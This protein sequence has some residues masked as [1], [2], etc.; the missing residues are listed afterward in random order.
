MNFGDEV[1][2]TPI[3]IAAFTVCFI[4][5]M[6]TTVNP[7]M[8]MVTA[9]TLVIFYRIKQYCLKTIRNI[10]RIEDSREGAGR[11]DQSLAVS[12]PLKRATEEGPQMVQ[13]ETSGQPPRQAANGYERAV[14]KAITLC[15]CCRKMV[16]QAL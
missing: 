1:L 9:V 5:L 2:N 14:R 3:A 13:M 12:K 7:W 11:Q 8:I 16:T 6:V 10:K 4:S 15:I